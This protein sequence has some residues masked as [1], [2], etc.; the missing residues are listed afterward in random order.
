VIAQVL[1]P[2]KRVVAIVG[3]SA[4]GFS[5]MEIETATRSHLP[6]LVFVINNNGI[7]FGLDASEYRRTTPLPSTAL[8]PNTRYDLIAEVW[9]LSECYSNHRHVVVEVS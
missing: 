5:A 1:D 6:L 7:Y 2:T 3:D 9:T 8:S 4:F